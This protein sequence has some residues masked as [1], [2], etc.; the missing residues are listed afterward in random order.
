MSW[1]VRIVSD[2][3]SPKL[4]SALALIRTYVTEAM[5]EVGA[6]MMTYSRGICPVRTGYLRSTVFFQITEEL[7]ADFGAAAPYSLFIEFGTYRMAAQPFIRPAIDAYT[8]QLLT[9]IL[10]GVLRVFE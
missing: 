4:A 7:E 3:F 1:G 10:Q 2:T 9:A 5:A 8:T 6:Q